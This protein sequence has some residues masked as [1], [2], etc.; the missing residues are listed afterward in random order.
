MIIAVTGTPGAGKTSIA[1]KL[2]T[3]LGF[4]YLDLNTLIKKEKLYDSYDCKAKTYDVDE[5]KLAKFMNTLLK[6]YAYDFADPYQQQL[7]DACN[8]H[9]TLKS[10]ELFKI[11][12]FKKNISSRT[13]KQKNIIV[14]SHLSHLFNSD[15]CF[16]VKTDIR[17]LR[18]RLASRGYSKQKIQDNIESEIFDVCLEE[19]RQAKQT[20]VVVHN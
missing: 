8:A 7:L 4:T 5:K 10:G 11:C 18:K 13:I 9:A 20:I 16:V 3:A 6:T 1:K 19:A 12:T 14:D 17:T 15:I 2:A